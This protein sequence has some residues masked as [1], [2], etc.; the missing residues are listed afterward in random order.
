MVR[1]ARELK[2]Q[3]KIPNAERL[4]GRIIDKYPGTEE[5]HLAQQL[6][7]QVKEGYNRVA[8]EQLRKAYVSAQKY[9]SDYPGG[10]IG[11]DGL[12]YYGLEESPNVTIDIIDDRQGQLVMTSEHSSGDKLYTVFFDGRIEERE[13]GSER[14]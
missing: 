9:F 5:A 4:C 3:K 6:L 14:T 2:D 10:T 11:L 12:H 13:M 8:Y 1:R 7:D